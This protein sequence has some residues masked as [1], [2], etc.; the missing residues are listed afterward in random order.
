MIRKSYAKI[1]LSLDVISEREDGYH[2]IETIMQ[3]INLYDEMKFEKINEGFELEIEGN[4]LSAGKDNLIYKAWEFME[5]YT[6]RKLPIRIK[7]KKNLPIAAGIAG[8]TGNGALT[9]E[10][11]NELYKLN[12]SKEELVKISVALGAD[13]PY[14]LKG[15][16]CKASGIGEKL[17][18][19]PDFTGVKV[20]VVNPGYGIS[21]KEVYENIEITGKTI[22]TEKII[23]NMKYKKADK[24][25]NLLYNKMEEGVFQ[26]Y[27]EIKLIKEKMERFGAVSLMSGSG[28]TVFGLFDNEIELEDAYLYFKE[29]Y[30]M[31]FKAETI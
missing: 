17:K 11:L 8:G 4:K 1:N 23:E 28:A 21:T 13:F 24:L 31:V 7:L 9:M 12:I 2:E 16:T 20:L 27:P 3:K 26:K 5:E 14:M 22:R 29:R 18:K 19:L 6:N 15:G 10:I 30:K 25:R